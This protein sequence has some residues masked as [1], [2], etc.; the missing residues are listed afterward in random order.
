MKKPKEN[1]DFEQKIRSISTTN[2]CRPLSYAEDSKN[3]KVSYLETRKQLEIRSAYF[4]EAIELCRHIIG[5]MK[6]VL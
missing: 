4:N 2:P 6:T 5:N 3:Y 1:Y